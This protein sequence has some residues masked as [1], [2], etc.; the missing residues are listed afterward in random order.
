M[1]KHVFYFIIKLI[2][3]SQIGFFIENPIML[4][5]IVKNSEKNNPSFF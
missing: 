5:K 1:K 2:E 3:L 4:V